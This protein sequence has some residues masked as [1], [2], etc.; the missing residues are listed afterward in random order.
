MQCATANDLQ[1]PTT[2]TNDELLKK[3]DRLAERL[4]FLLDDIIALADG[5]YL[6]DTNWADGRVAREGGQQ[7]NRHKMLLDM[8][9]GAPFNSDTAIDTAEYEPDHERYDTPYA[10]PDAW[11]A[12]ILDI[13]LPRET[14]HDG[15]PLEQRERRSD[16]VSFGYAIG[17]ILRS[18]MPESENSETATDIFWGLSLGL[19]GDGSAG[20]PGAIPAFEDVLSELS[21][22]HRRRKERS[23]SNSDLETI[24]T[25]MRGN[26][27]KTQAVKNGIRD[28]DVWPTAPVVQEVKTHGFRTDKPEWIRTDATKITEA[29]IE[30]TPLAEVQTLSECVVKDL[31]AVREHGLQGVESLI[32]PLLELW[33]PPSDSAGSDASAGGDETG[34][35]AQSDDSNGSRSPYQTAPERFTDQIGDFERSQATACLNRLNDNDTESETEAKLVWKETGNA[36]GA[37]WQL[38]PYGQVICAAATQADSEDDIEYVNVSWIYAYAVA[39]HHLQLY[40]RAA[41]TNT[42]IRLNIADTR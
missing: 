22:R 26:D 37:K 30:E 28:A 20:Q 2:A 4:Q 3:R 24:L 40:Q 15:P 32:D 7:I 1:R 36:R 23:I 29:L 25:R 16:E 11:W 12:D 9:S 38:T 19:L 6:T 34:A 8:D 33:R 18:L 27:E 17:T 42:L 31:S 10:G 13:D 39:P 5:E 14:E 35:D 41:I 21:T